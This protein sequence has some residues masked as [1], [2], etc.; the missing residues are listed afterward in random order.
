MMTTSGAGWSGAVRDRLGPGRLLP[1]GEATDG[2]WLTESAAR[3]VL[4]RSLA[5]VRG[6]VPGKLRV[7]LAEVGPQAPFPVP[8]GGLPPGSLRITA[9]FAVEA[10]RM[11][12]APLPVLAEEA[13]EALFAAAERALGL[14]VTAVDLRVTGLV[15]VAPDSPG[16]APPPGRTAPLDEEDGVAQAVL[17]VA[18][19]AGLTSLLGAPVHR[20]AG[21]LRV[22]LAVTD[23]HRALDVARTARTRATVT[24]PEGTAVTVLVS[25]VRFSGTR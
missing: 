8:P 14:V 21:A 10:G 6:V 1:L 3:A 11:A 12:D 23:G 18:G 25:E 5:P 7:G 4:L 24:A 9:D 17:G 2:A 16:T 20:T 19:V 15:E 22:E 13:R